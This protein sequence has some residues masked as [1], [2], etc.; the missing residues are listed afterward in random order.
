MTPF[1]PFERSHG[2]GQKIDIPLARFA[3][4]DVVGAQSA[5][6]V[7]DPTENVVK[8]GDTQQE[9]APSAD[10]TAAEASPTGGS[11][12]PASAPAGGAAAPGEAR[13]VSGGLTMVG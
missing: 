12:A 5:P 9:H 1:E 3:I 2:V 13:S 10:R 8:L 11:S 4:G 6:V 7:F